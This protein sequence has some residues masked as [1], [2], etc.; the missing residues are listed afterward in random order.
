MPHIQREADPE[1]PYLQA[2]PDSGH[3][4]PLPWPHAAQSHHC[5]SSVCVSAKSF[6]SCSTLCDPMDPSG[7][8]VH[9]ILRSRTLEWVAM[10]SS[11]GYSQPS[12]QTHI[13]SVFRIGRWV[14]YHWHHLGSPTSSLH[15]SKA[16]LRVS[17]LPSFPPYHLFLTRRFLW[18]VKSHLSSAQ[19]PEISFHIIQSQTSNPYNGHRSPLG[20]ALSPLHLSDFFC[21][22]HPIILVPVT[23]ASSL[24]LNT[25]QQLWNSV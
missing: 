11:R 12:D 6:Q 24:F 9:G 23:P 18:K 8:P 1:V 7:S 5:L 20:S 21:P 4:S 22:L 15:R 17:P 14:P 25:T 16:F 2:D 3:F 13:P 10:T 19:N